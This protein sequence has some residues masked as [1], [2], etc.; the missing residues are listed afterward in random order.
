MM[1]IQADTWH[2][3]IWKAF[4]ICPL[5]HLPPDLLEFRLERD[6]DL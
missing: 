1:I 2:A 4:E 6:I 5:E 3:L